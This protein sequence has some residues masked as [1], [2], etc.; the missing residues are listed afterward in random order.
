MLAYSL[1]KD[2]F[3]DTSEK[4]MDCDEFIIITYCS[5]TE[6]IVLT[7]ISKDFDLCLHNEDHVNDEIA[8]KLFK[9]KNKKFKLYLDFFN[10]Q[11]KSTSL[12]T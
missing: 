2:L 5:K 7:L 11:V 8:L 12:F 6:D 9:S 10:P 3:I 4:V 1:D